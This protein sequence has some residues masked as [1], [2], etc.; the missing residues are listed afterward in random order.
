MLAPDLY[1]LK[2]EPLEIKFQHQAKKLAPSVLDE[3]VE[4]KVYK[5][6]AY[7]DEKGEGWVFVAYSPDEIVE[8]LKQAG[9]DPSDV[10][11]VYFAQQSASMFENPIE[12]DAHSA[13]GL[14]N[15]IVTI[16]PKAFYGERRFLSF[17]ESFRPNIKGVSLHLAQENAP[18]AP[19]D[20]IILA[21]VFALLGMLFLFEG[22]GYSS[23]QSAQ[24]ESIDTL[25]ADYPSLQSGYSRQ[26]IAKKYQKR[27]DKERKKREYL[28]E[29]SSVVRYGG[30]V[31]EITIDS[32]TMKTKMQISNKNSY[33]SVNKSIKVKQID[34][35]TIELEASV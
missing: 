4:R 30:V 3:L 21:S 16:M 26:S 12:L 7:K 28:K 13:L 25:L 6:S 8:I 33:N 19:K 2:Q 1:T 34:A 31:E 14:I 18:I 29:I 27:D 15:G 23:S 17:D 32:K 10:H 20:A 35:K 11:N 9:V 5:Y 22:F 24:R